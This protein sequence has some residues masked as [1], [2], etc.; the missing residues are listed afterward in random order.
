MDRNLETEAQENKSNKAVQIGERLVYYR[1]K[2]I[3]KVPTKDGPSLW[4]AYN[5][6]KNAAPCDF[7]FA[8][9]SLTSLYH[10]CS[11]FQEEI[12]LP[13]CPDLLEENDYT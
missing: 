12:D 2:F 4:V 7:T 11:F 10:A 8:T 9:K 3:L 1:R 5:K 13:L 6:M